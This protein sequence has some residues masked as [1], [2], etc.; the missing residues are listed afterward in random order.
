MSYQTAYPV[1]PSDTADVRAGDLADALFVGGAG[2]GALKVM[3]SDGQDC[4]FAGVG[5]G[6]LPIKV[7]RVYSTGTNVT[8]IVAL[9]F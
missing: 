3:M 2:S 4:A 5:V 8:N 1:T 6:I 9:K 7:K